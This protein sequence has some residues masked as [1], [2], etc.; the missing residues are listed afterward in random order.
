MNKIKNLK[1]ISK[2]LP[3]LKGK[4]IGLAH[5]VFDI[6]HFGHLLHLKKA[7]SY[8]DILFVSITS[9]KFINKGPGRPIYNTK[10]RLNIVA[11]IELVDFVITSNE[12]TSKNIIKTLKPDIYFKGND[13]QE[14]SKDYTGGIKVEKREVEKFGGKILFTNEK[15]LSST[16]LINRFSNELNDNTKAYLLKLRKKFSFENIRNLIEKSSSVKTLVIGEII[17]DEYV[18][19]L[20]MGKSPKE[21]LISMQESKKETYAGGIA[22]SVNHLSNLLSDC[23]LLSVVPSDYNTRVFNKFINKNIKKIFFREKNYNFIT[24]TRYLDEHNNKL[25]QISNKKKNDI[26]KET[27]NKIIN[28]L[29]KNL[30]KFDHVIVHDFGHGLISKK[31]IR[32]IEKNS[33]YLSINVQT[34]SS[35]IGFNYLTKFSKTN[36][37]SIDEPEARL[38]LSD[39]YSNTSKLFEKFRAKLKYKSGSIT[40]GKNGAYTSFNN[41]IIFSPALTSTPIDTLGAGDAFFVISSIISK[42]SN[43]PEKIGFLGNIAGAFAVN[44]LGHKKYL[45]KEI[46][47]NY[48]KTYLNI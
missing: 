28:Y 7:K 10:Q 33:K 37:F 47:L 40:F 16:N 13:Y 39:E 19:C 21:Q 41:K 29:K 44:Y 24:K 45:N 1:E 3:K 15:T 43:D 42:V 26:K 9:N 27:E 14:H 34:N 20:P 23:S 18:F 5:G 11:S 8:C 38:A 36:Y 46:L 30:K 17:K 2:I 25:F 6:F 48:V 35:N 12:K 32:F 4:K 31:M 22:A